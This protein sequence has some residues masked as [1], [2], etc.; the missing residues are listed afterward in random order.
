MKK[1]IVVYLEDI[2]ESVAKIEEYTAGITFEGFD[3]DTERQ[4]AVIRRLEIIG[5]AVKSLPADV[6]ERHPN[7]PWK[8]RM[9]A[10]KDWAVESI[11][12]RPYPLGLLKEYGSPHI[13]ITIRP[14]SQRRDRARSARERDTSGSF[15][16]HCRRS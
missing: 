12:Y 8:H 14:V 9:E 6:K 15:I 1:G 5:E 3:G 11:S 10:E 7:I 13:Q 4:D 2:I 16:I